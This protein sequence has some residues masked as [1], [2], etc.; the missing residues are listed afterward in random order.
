MWIKNKVSGLA[1][2]IV[3]IAVGVTFI[4]T[5]E[6][7]NLDYA[8]EAEGPIAVSVGALFCLLGAWIFARVLHE[9]RKKETPHRQT[10]LPKR[11]GS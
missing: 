6:G 1:Y 8:D 3:T 10:Q 5:R 2:L 7:N 9:D 11:P 4:C